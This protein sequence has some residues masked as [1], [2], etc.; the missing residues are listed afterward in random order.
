MAKKLDRDAFINIKP[1]MVT[2]LKLKG[3][4]LLIYAAI[5][6]FSI[7]EE[8][9]FHGSIE[10]LQTW[11]NSSKQSVLDVL[12][13]LLNKGLIT[14]TKIDNKCYYRTT[15]VRKCNESGLKLSNKQS[16]ESLPNGQESLPNTVKIIDLYGQ[17]SGHNNKYIT[18]NDNKDIYAP[19]PEP[20][21]YPLEEPKKS[22]KKSDYNE[23]IKLIHSCQNTLKSKNI[24]VDE[25]EYPYSLYSKT[26]KKWFTEYGV[27]KVKQGILNSINFKWLVDKKYSINILFSE[28]IFP[29]CVSNS[30]TKSTSSPSKST[31]QID[32]QNQNYKEEF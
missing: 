24:T 1:F 9:D 17:E 28:K 5:F 22:F 23:C 26:L 29:Q 10:Y 7:D 11:T 25:T 12:K 6:G 13:S 16:Q 4:E 2:D 30:F 3:N 8:S 20:E 19:F 15:D 21:D 27:D 18:N 14:K 32:Y 31:T